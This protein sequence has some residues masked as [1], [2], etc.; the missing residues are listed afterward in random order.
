MNRGLEWL[1]PANLRRSHALQ[2]LSAKRTATRCEE[3][4]WLTPF[5]IRELW[6][7][8]LFSVAIRARNPWPIASAHLDGQEDK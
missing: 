5:H 8:F 7:G 2:T 4:Y 1:L 3:E 6:C